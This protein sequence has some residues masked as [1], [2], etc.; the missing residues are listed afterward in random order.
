MQQK[1][2]RDPAPKPVTVAIRRQGGARIVT[3]PPALLASIGAD[4]G[5]TLLLEVRGG[6]LVAKPVPD[7]APTPRKRYTL[8]QLLKGSDAV[9]ALNAE[10]AW[11]QDGEPV[12]RE[13]G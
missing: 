4:A 2:R 7:P 13:I 1:K 11:V 5:T 9:A 10:T 6:S 12:G 8:A 3:L